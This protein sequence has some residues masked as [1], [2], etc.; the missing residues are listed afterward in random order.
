MLLE[1]ARDLRQSGVVRDDRRAAGRGS[2]RRHHPERLREDRGCGRRVG[3]R[4]Q[5]HEVAVLER[6]G[7]ERVEARRLTLELLSVVAEAD[8]HRPHV[9]PADSV[10][11]HLHALV[12]DQLSVVDDGRSVAREELGEPLRV[13]LIR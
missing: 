7:E 10:E 1:A 9:E 6:P 8:D 3:E 2:L 13:A 12:L 11:Q 5:M 4:E